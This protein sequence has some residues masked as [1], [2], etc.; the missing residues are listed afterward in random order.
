MCGVKYSL[1]NRDKRFEIK[2]NW[3]NETSLRITEVLILDDGKN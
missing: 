1:L 2:I 3:K